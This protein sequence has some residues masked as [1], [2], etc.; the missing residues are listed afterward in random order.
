ME[1]VGLVLFIFRLLFSYANKAFYIRYI[2]GCRAV[3][4]R[5]VTAYINCFLEDEKP[6]LGKNP[7]VGMVL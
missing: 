7:G 2:A 4:A 6:A 5:G 1:I 3:I